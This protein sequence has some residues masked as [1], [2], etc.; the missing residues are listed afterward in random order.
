MESAVS[1]RAGH[2]AL[3]ILRDEGLRKERITAIAGASGGPKFLVLNQLD[4][5]VFG[6]WLTA[7]EHPVLFIGSSIG[8]W[9]AAALAQADPLAAL[10]KLTTA[11]IH[12]D[13]SDGIAPQDITRESYA[14]LDAFLD[15]EKIAQ[16]LSHPWLRV[17]FLSA[18]SRTPWQ[19]ESH[20]LMIPELALAFAANVISRKWLSLFVERIIF[21]DV[22]SSFPFEALPGFRNKTYQLTVENFRQA[23][24][25]SGSIPLVME[26]V[27]TIP[28][29]PA[30][31][32]R[33]GGMIDY[34][35]DLPLHKGE[36]NLVFYPHFY[37]H[38]IPGW[39][40]KRLSW[41]K[42]SA[43]HVSNMVIVSPSSDFIRSLPYGKIPDRKDF[44]RFDREERL[45]YWKT[46]ARRSREMAEDFAE[47]LESGKIKKQ[48][49]LLTTND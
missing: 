38:V 48:V 19:F 23:L 14:I 46:V 11:Y 43:N 21:F 35:H 24:L 20:A 16:I 10:E 22:R 28:G 34:H 29:L 45:V 6:Q 47:A 42:P 36:E 27:T 1:I 25:A 2:R 3:E 30:G 41:R 15:E 8:S 13:Y 44:K 31:N 32:Y 12:Q 49:K 37:D 17:A 40:D 26:D 5:F 18:K 33:D 4:H 39:L 9:R 7:S